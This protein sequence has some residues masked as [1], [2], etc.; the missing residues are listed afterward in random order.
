MHQNNP[1]VDYAS[2][3]HPTIS[4]T[5]LSVEGI[6]LI[7]SGVPHRPTFH[8][9]IYPSLHARTYT[10]SMSPE[11]ASLDSLSS[12]DPRRVIGLFLAKLLAYLV[13]LQANGQTVIFDDISYMVGSA[14]ALVNHCIRMQAAAQLKSAGF[15]DAARDMRDPDSFVCRS[16]RAP[17]ARIERAQ[18]CAPAAPAELIDRLKTTI[19]TFDRADELASAF[20]SMILCA[21][22]FVF[23]ETRERDVHP[24]T[25]TCP[26]N[27]Q[28]KV[29]LGPPSITPVGQG[30]PYLL[31]GQT[32]PPLLVSSALSLAI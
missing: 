6:P 14:E 32:G 31:S 28:R 12:L 15:T 19:E 9:K 13:R 26:L 24:R 2:L 5:H 25:D 7:M 16:S 27:E 17:S 30:P 1:A 18:G 22:A 21:L 23:P 11:P 3:I 10:R 8:Q 20:A 4:L 29:G